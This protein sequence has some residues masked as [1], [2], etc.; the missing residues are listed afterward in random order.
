MAVLFED[1]F[2][3]CYISISQAFGV[4]QYKRTKF[5]LVV[6]LRLGIPI[7]PFTAGLFGYICPRNLVMDD[8][9]GKGGLMEAAIAKS[10]VCLDLV[11]ENKT[12]K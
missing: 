12:N 2:C 3:T 10:R 11:A 1:H 6:R 5:I 8:I 9:L 4:L 7:I